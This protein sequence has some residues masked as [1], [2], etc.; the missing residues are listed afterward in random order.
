MVRV[1]AAESEYAAYR[2]RFLESINHGR[3]EIETRRC[4]V[5]LRIRREVRR[6]ARKD[7]DNARRFLECL[8]KGAPWRRY[9]GFGEEWISLYQGTAA[10]VETCP[11]LAF[12]ADSIE[13][14]IGGMNV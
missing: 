13:S 9:R 11:W 1:T 12:L 7:P 3:A 8:Y 6:A 2:R 10:R 14:A 5:R 4:L